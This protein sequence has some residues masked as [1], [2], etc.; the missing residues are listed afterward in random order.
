MGWDELGN[1]FKGKAPADVARANTYKNQIIDT[2]VT[3]EYIGD[4]YD[5]YD[6]NNKIAASYQ[7]SSSKCFITCLRSIIGHFVRPILYY[8]KKAYIGQQENHKE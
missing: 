6:E 3:F 2:D 1:S 4:G 8:K 5:Y 7:W